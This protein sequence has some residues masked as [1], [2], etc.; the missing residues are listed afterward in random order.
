MKGKV[1]VATLIAAFISVYTVYKEHRE[2]VRLLEQ[3]RIRVGKLEALPIMPFEYRRVLTEAQ[4]VP[5][6]LCRQNPVLLRLFCA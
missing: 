3:E 2:S 6:A 1:I 4:K 5:H